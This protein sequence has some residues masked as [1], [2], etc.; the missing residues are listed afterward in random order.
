M[1]AATIRTNYHDIYL[2]VGVAVA[3]H[4]AIFFI[5][6]LL[7]L[8]D[9]LV[10]PVK[11]VSEPKPKP[12]P[13]PAEVTHE[14]VQLNAE[15][16]Q[17]MRAAAA[18]LPNA[19]GGVTPPEGEPV[20]AKLTTDP[21][22][23]IPPAADPEPDPEVADEPEPIN[24]PAP[25]RFEK[26]EVEQ[27]SEKPEEAS[28]IGERNTQEASED[29]AVEEGPELPTQEGEVRN[30][31][32]VEILESRFEEGEEPGAKAAEE[33]QA[34]I[35]G[36]EE[37]EENGTGTPGLEVESE[38]AEQGKPLEDPL[39][40]SPNQIDVPTEPR[41][42]VEEELPNQESS[43]KTDS[44][45]ARKGVPGEEPVEKE[46]EEDPKEA[47]FRTEAFRT[48]IRGSIK[49]RGKSA[50]NVDKTAVGQ[51]RGKVYREIEKAWRRH[52]LT[53]RN[54]ILPGSLTL[55]FFIDKDGKVSDERYIYIFQTSVIQEG[56]TVNSV[57]KTKFPP[58][59]EEVLKELDGEKL[60]CELDFNFR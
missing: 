35:P 48:K 34:P 49:R 13:V 26:T 31:N 53:Y 24:V 25:S 29:P 60:P 59:P 18:L 37:G 27:E 14:T 44:E 21:D 40:T 41:K 58:M 30:D 32:E 9:I 39:Q 56:F 7:A 57:S 52:C 2:A 33:A 50:L 10:D 4:V 20:E 11:E 46:V 19:P 16:F 1:S 43:N 5:L 38:N 15:F 3:V 28:L 45:Q 17:Q 51:Y 12:K 55:R 8:V 23:V 6:V 54:H 42:D 47:G 36:V 22:P